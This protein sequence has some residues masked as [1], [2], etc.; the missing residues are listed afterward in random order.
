[1][2]Q[3]LTISNSKEMF[4][5]RSDRIVYVASDGNY[6]VIHM[7]DGDQRVVIRK[8]LEIE[9]L[10]GKQFCSCVGEKFIR[11]GRELIINT[12][13]VYYINP[14]RQQILLCD[15]ERVKVELSAP[16]QALKL[17]KTYFEEK[18]TTENGRD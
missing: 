11:V 3:Y 8:L 5:F 16:K 12:D 1:M 13:Y 14:N 2:P 18:Y 6:S 7:S 17:L 15:N 10:M 4:R 9:E